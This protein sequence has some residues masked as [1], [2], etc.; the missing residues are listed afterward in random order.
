MRQQRIARWTVCALGMV[1][2]ALV[3]ARP[4][5]AAQSAAPAPALDAVFARFTPDTPGCA[6][7]VSVDGA[8]VASRGYGMADLEHDVPITPDTIFEAGSVSKQFTAAA[9]LLLARDGALSLDDPV[10]KYLPEVPDYGRPLTI[11][12]LLNHTSGL[13]DWGALAGIAGW[14]RT[15]RVHTHAHVLEIVSRQIATNFTPGTHWSYSNTGYNLAAILVAR[16]SGQSFAD[17]TRTRIFAPL[18]MTHTSW[19]DDHTRIVKGRAIGY[20]ERDGAFHTDMPFETVHGNGGLLTTVGDLLRWNE[21]L[22]HPT[23]GDASFV[24]EEQ[25]PVAFSPGAGHGY[26]LGLMLDHRR[27]VVQ[28]DHSGSTA[29]YLAHL[30]RY[31]EQQVGVAVLCNLS[32]AAA[33]QKAYDAADLYLSSRATLAPAPAPTHSLS[34]EER[35]KVVGL[36]ASRLDG[37][38]VT[39]VVDGEGLRMA[40]GALLLAQSATHFLTPGGQMWTL[41]ADG[42]L[43]STDRYDVVDYD[44]VSPATPPAAHLA[45]FAGAYVSDEIETRLDVRVESGALVIRRRPDTRLT[46]TPVYTDAFTAPE[47]GFVRFR[48]DASGRVNA[49]SVVQDRV[50]DLRF[51]RQSA[52]PGATRPTAGAGPRP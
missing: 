16:V 38:P 41:E 33:T 30:A 5:V 26:A 39:V 34:A 44:R 14:P 50:W 11:R 35:A 47:L 20:D 49:L 15:T 31:P 1:V 36:Y 2:G 19:R 48:R 45:A 18:G 43:R 51:V 4:G 9:V 12:H 24:A 21:Q 22:A 29:G 46:L 13:R 3:A 17:F 23:I 27:G 8:V 40:R 42:H 25:R 32:T 37:R 10:R 6:V 28:I 52:G 7:G